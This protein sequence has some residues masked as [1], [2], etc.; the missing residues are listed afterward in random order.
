MTR[1]SSESSRSCKVVRP[2]LRAASSSTRLEMLLEPGRVTVPPAD[3]QG[4]Q[5]EKAVADM[6]FAEVV[7]L[8]ELPVGC[9]RALAC[10]ISASSASPSPCDISA[11]EGLQLALEGIGFAPATLSRL[12]KQDVAPDLGV[13]GSNAGEVA[14]ARA[15]Q[16]QEFLAL[17]L[18]RR[19]RS[20]G[21]TP[22]GAA[23]G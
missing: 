8:L 14:K 21:Q 17:G 11:L 1:V 4:R 9:A 15:R 22:A 3:C 2:R 23:S 19:W 6:R 20:S 13:A 7:M 5:I 10:A 18:A 12:D 16:R